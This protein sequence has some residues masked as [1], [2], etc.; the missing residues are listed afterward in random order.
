M[1]ELCVCAFGDFYA[2]RTPYLVRLGRFPLARAVGLDRA[3][4]DL[5]PPTR[6]WP[7]QLGHGLDSPNA[8]RIL[9]MIFG[10]MFIF[11]RY[12]RILSREIYHLPD[13]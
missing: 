11:C 12:P 10:S 13:F 1:T 3:M 6:A 4:P 9:C 8:D 2:D 7:C 5:D